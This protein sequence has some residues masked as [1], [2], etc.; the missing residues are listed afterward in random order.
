MST[1]SQPSPTPVFSEPAREEVPSYR[2]VSRWAVFSVGLALLS[3]AGLIFPGLLA[4]ALGGVV[5][6]FVALSGI[7]RYPDELTGAP[8]AWV[9]IVL[10]GV[11]FLTGTAKHVHEYVTELPE[12][13]TD[14]NR[15]SFSELQPDKKRP[16]LP[17]SPEA[18][19]LNGQKIF[20]KG[21]IH[22]EFGGGPVK[23]FVLVPDMGTCCFGGDPKPTDMI[24][25][26]LQGDKRITYNQR[27][28]KVA[29]VFRVDPYPRRVPGMK[30]GIYYQIDAEYAK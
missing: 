5:C 24:E 30:N 16:E 13:Y 25:V 27:L 15:H 26:N 4:L 3:I 21:Y 7:R 28:R 1:I 8:A 18:L 14:E 20:L 6:G 9:G 29:G 22:P 10:C 2:A 23:K 17:V 19:E 12:G 11:L